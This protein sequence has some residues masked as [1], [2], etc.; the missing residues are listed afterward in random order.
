MTVSSV[1]RVLPTRTIYPPTHRTA[2]VGPSGRDIAEL[3]NPIENCWSKV[4]EFL[5]SELLELMHNSI[6]QS[7]ML[8][9]P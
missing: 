4:K 3:F 8:L 1:T 9:M 5:R 2:R 6:K 7:L